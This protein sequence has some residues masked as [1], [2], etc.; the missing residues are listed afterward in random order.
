VAQLFSLDGANPDAIDYPVA[1]R[2]NCKDGNGFT[3]LELL[4]VI[5]I[6]AILAALLLPA[7]SRGKDNARRTVCLNDLKQ[8]S[9][10]I[11]MYLD[12]QNNGSPGNTNMTHSPFLSWTDYRGLINNY[13]GVNGAS[14][15]QDKV[16][17]CPADTFFYGMHHND[18]GYVPQPL[19]EQ[20]SYAYTSYA[21]NA[22]EFTTRATTNVSAS[23][24]YYGIAGQRLDSVPH[25]TTT[26]LIAEM[27]AFVPYSWHEPKR[28]F[29]TD[30]AHF[31]DAK[32]MVGF[33]D[34]HVSYLRI[35]YDGDKI[36]WDYN[37]PAGY[38]YQWS[39]D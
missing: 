12:D 9:L 27:P 31:N 15:P 32:N 22:G 21:Y 33:V 39:G 16:F 17:A 13:V 10:G 28:P 30:N 1:L 8:I 37:P 25:P 6:I 19:H 18:H 38:D 4:V 5:A 35:Y 26:V 11:H 23:T 29:S 20:S 34:G 24:N 3:L 14:S 36:S 7:I 2:T